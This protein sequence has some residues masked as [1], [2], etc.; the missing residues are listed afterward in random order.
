VSPLVNDVRH[1]AVPPL[2]RSFEI[3]VCRLYR[4]IRRPVQRRRWEELPGWTWDRRAERWDD[5]YGRL[6]SYVKRHGNALVPASHS[7]DGFKLG[8]WVVAQR[9][10]YQKGILQDDR[11]M[12]LERLP[13][14]TW[15]PI[16]AQWEE[17]FSTLLEYVECHGDARVP[18]RYVFNSYKLGNWAAAQ[19]DSYAEGT[20]NADREH[21][22]RDLPG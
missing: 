18:A 8:A 16:A 17:G 2:R 22:L 6:L 11:R 20:L 1:I 3:L 14:W 4:D 9:V 12:R 10:N 13:G 21:R 7:V 15:K 19:R 5:G